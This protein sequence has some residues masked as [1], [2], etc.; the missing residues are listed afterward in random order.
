MKRIKVVTIFIGGVTQF[1]SYRIRFVSG[2]L[3]D[4]L[5][6]EGYEKTLLELLQIVDVLLVGLQG[7]SRIL[8][9]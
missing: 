2:S 7:E 6:V 3:K 1:N 8:K 4:L 9:V 5:N